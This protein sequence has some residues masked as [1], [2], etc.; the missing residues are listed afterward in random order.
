MMEN[1]KKC[2]MDLTVFEAAEFEKMAGVLDKKL[3]AISRLDTAAVQ[4]IVVQELEVLKRIQT[5]EKDRASVLKA[6][7]LSGTDFN[8]PVND[9]NGGALENKL[10]KED[11]EKFISLHSDLK[12][13][14]M[15]VQSLNGICRA[16]LKHSL[17]F[18]R[19]NI[20]IL[21]EGGSRRLVDRKA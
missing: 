14:F 5:I 19:H 4:N 8:I 3:R 1:E 20:H 15:K 9:R 6:L 11:S 13:S 7:S 10:G 17:S 16:L 18:I 12:K 21:T 2:L